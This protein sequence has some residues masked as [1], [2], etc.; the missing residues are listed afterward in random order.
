[1]I[2]MELALLQVCLVKSDSS[3][4]G[5]WLLTTIR[6]TLFLTCSGNNHICALAVKHNAE[7]GGRARCWGDETEEGKTDPPKDVSKEWIDDIVVVLPLLSLT[8]MSL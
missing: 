2:L 1:M 7:V 6:S 3:V 8:V 5:Q 4:M